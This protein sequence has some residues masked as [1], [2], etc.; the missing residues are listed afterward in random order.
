M[1]FSA[2]ADLVAAVGVG[3]VAVDA[4][5]HVRAPAQWWLASIPVVLAAHQLVEALV[6]LSLEGR[7]PDVVGRIAIWGYL[8]IAFG[9]LPILVPIAVGAL[10]PSTNRVRAAAFG[11]LGAG[12]AA[13]LMYAVIDGP[14][15]AR[16]EGRHIDYSVDLWHGHFVVVMYVVATCGSLLV[17]RHTHVRWFGAVN[18]VAVSLI[19]W[20]DQNALISLWCLWAALTSVG[21]A[22]HLR[23]V[24]K[25][26]PTDRGDG[27]ST[28]A[29]EDGPARPHGIFRMRALVRPLTGPSG[30][31]C[32][33]AAHP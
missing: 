9:L 10:E 24:A 33:A 25:A 30:G 15:E 2:Q 18:L 6:W 14:V 32:G 23:A 31:C 4:V 12:V 8:A 27:W 22:L 19:A 17:S 26:S 1:C 28:R 21:V 7:V 11:V 29:G 20:V 13:V 16:I 5:R 3:I